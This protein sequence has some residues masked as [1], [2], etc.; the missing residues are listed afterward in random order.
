M[1][2]QTKNLLYLIYNRVEELQYGIYAALHNTNWSILNDSGEII[3][4]D[5]GKSRPYIIGKY[6]F[7]SENNRTDATDDKLYSYNTYQMYYMVHSISNGTVSKDASKSTISEIE[8]ITNN[9]YVV[10][11]LGE[12]SLVD[13]TGKLLTLPIY[14]SMK[15]YN[16]TSTHIKFYVHSHLTYTTERQ[17]MKQKIMMQT[18]EDRKCR[19]ANYILFDKINNTADSIFT[20]N[21]IEDSLE[22]MA[23]T[24]VKLPNVSLDKFVTNIE[25]YRKFRELLDRSDFNNSIRYKLKYNNVPDDKDYESIDLTFTLKAHKIASTYD[26]DT[27]GLARYTGEVIVP[28]GKYDNTYYLGGGI[29]IGYKKDA[30]YNIYKNGVQI[31]GDNKISELRTGPIG[32]VPYMVAKYQNMWLYVGL[33]GHLYSNINQAFTFYISA[34]NNN[35][36][37]MQMYAGEAIVDTQ[38]NLLN[39]K[40][41]KES[42]IQEWVKIT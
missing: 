13:N 40:N 14:S 30:G 35:I 1:D 21:T 17:H 9:I 27:Q 4:E 20:F 37:K 42:D 29:G 23:V 39:R 34:T 2:T 8:Q 32:K 10:N 15:A 28:T 26:G 41:L 22:I 33:D 31:I 12:T 3:I 16:Q 25:S 38:L 11:I 19:S 7:T 18:L 36:Y 6:L 24:N 5:C